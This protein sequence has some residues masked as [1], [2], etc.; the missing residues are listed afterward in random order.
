MDAA[1][2]VAETTC[3]LFRTEPYTEADAAHHP[4][5]EAIPGSQLGRFGTY[6]YHGCIA[7]R[8][9]RPWNRRLII[10]ATP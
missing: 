8:E 9:E 3:T 10:A 2:D 7:D 6:S 4:A 5:G 1:A